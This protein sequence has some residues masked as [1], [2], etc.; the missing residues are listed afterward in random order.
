MFSVISVS[1]DLPANA[2]LIQ[3]YIQEKNAKILHGQIYMEGRGHS[4][5]VLFDSSK[6]AG[7]KPSLF[8]KLNGFNGYVLY[9]N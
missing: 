6:L 3:R 8:Q 9:Q 7:F 2:Y 5:T 4:Q 1:K